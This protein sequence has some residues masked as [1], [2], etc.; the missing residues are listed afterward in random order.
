MEVIG[1]GDVGAVDRMATAVLG[2]ALLTLGLGRRSLGG[3]ALALASGGLLYRSLRGR[4]PVLQKG[5]REEGALPERAAGMGAA[6]PEVV[7]SISIGRPAEE[8]FELWRKPETLTRV[9]ADFADVRETAPGTQRWRVHA[10]R[11]RSLEW[12]SRILESR[13]GELLSW[14]AV[15]GAALPNE[16]WVRFRP[17]PGEWGTEVTLCFRFEPPG[18]AMGRALMERLNVVP[19]LL[20]QRALRRFKSLA[21]T[22]E[23][24]TLEHNPAARATAH[25]H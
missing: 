10:P 1:R 18:G 17:A 20:A 25:V 24:P 8:L 7:R 5:G 9:M 2:G 16:G 22:G 14:R 4:G 11:G 13:P 15:A 12:E 3:T 6:S 19:R 23:I 21:E